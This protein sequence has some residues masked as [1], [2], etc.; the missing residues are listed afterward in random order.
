MWMDKS[1]GLFRWQ[2][3]DPPDL[4]AVRSKDGG[5]TVLDA[6]KKEARVWSKAALESEDKQGRGQGFAMLDSMQHATLADFDQDFGLAAAEQDTA[7]PAIWHFD[8]RFKDG[9]I[10][11]A[12]LRLAISVNTADGSMGEFTLHMR[13]GSSLST[14]IRGYQLNQ[15]IPAETFKVDTAGY[16]VEAM[17]PKS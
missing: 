5:M 11:I 12:V 1:G 6:R 15:S 10:S 16:K 8:W 7:N 17:N 13:D 2:V 3:G 4:L 9:K 14:V